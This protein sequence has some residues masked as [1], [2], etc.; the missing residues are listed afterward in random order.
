M[1]VYTAFWFGFGLAVPL[2]AFSLF[3]MWAFCNLVRE[4]LYVRRLQR[5]AR[6]RGM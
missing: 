4:I 3:G 2:G 6:S 1:D 5:R